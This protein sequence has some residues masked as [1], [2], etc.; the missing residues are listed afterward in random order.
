MAG[1]AGKRFW[2][3]SRKDLPK[4]FLTVLSNKSMI[5]M[6]VERL[7]PKI[8]YRD[9]YVVTTSAQRELVREHLPDIPSANIIVEPEGMNTAPAVALSSIFLGKRYQADDKM[10]VLPAD[11]IINDIPLFVKSIETA[12]KAADNNY[13]VT[14]GISPT[15]PATG[16]GYIEGGNDLGFGLSVSD[17]KEKPDVET[18]KRFIASGNYFWN[19]GMFFWKIGEILNAYKRY[20][21]KVFS[22]MCKIGCRWEDDGIDADISDIYSQMPKISVDIGIMEQAERRV[23][24]PVCYGWSDIGG[25]KALYD[26]L[27]KDSGGNVFMCESE[28]ISSNGCYVNSRKFVALAGVK[29]LVVVDTSDALLI[30]NKE[31]SEN[32]KDIVGTLEKKGKEYLT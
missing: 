28:A 30:V 29:D 3:L 20:L 2:P 7:L 27:P 14:F 5:Q 10:F 22:L 23:V 1:G 31:Y 16:Y 12:V 9:I 17:F 6:T 19:G 4:Q 11:Q 25:W 21:P 8:P 13:L 15:Y 26:I 24:V 18:A 32:V